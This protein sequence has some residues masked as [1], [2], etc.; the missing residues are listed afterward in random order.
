M[1]DYAADSSVPILDRGRN[2]IE[3]E[4]GSSTMFVDHVLTT[5]KLFINIIISFWVYEL[6]QLFSP[7]YKPI[8]PS[9]RLCT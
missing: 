4:I 5:V 9:D 3:R 6:E 1:P 7:S 2:A 8:Y